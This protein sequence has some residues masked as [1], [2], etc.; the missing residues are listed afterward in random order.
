MKLVFEKVCVFDARAIAALTGTN[1]KAPEKAFELGTAKEF[2][3][4]ARADATSVWVE[5][6]S[7]ISK[8]RYCELKTF[9]NMAERTSTL[10]M[11]RIGVDR[12]RVY[13]FEFGYKS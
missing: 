10:E 4:V 11:F 8:V 1:A 5:R 2:A 12:Y 7:T 3:V 6:S 13:E 9:G